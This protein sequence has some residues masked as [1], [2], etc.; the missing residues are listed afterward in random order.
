MEQSEISGETEEDSDE[1]EE[2]AYGNSEKD[3]EMYAPQVDIQM[4]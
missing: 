4:E 1:S 3:E 2:D